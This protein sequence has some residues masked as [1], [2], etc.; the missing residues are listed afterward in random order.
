MCRTRLRAA[1]CAIP[2]LW[3]TI[4]T[5]TTLPTDDGTLSPGVLRQIAALEQEKANR[6]EVEQRIDPHLL[7]AHKMELG[8]PIADNVQT[9]RVLLDWDKNGLV[10]LDIKAEVTGALL[11]FLKSHGAKVINAFREYRSVRARM[12]LN[13]VAALAAR[14]DVSFVAPAV[15]AQ[16]N[17]VDIEGDTVHQA[18]KARQVYGVDGT[19]VR[20]GVL[21]DSVDYLTNSVVNGFVTILPGQDG[22]PATGEGTAML[23]I[24]HILAPGAQLFFA[25]AGGG[26]ANF[27]NN[28]VQLRAAGCDIIV[29]DSA[30]FDESPF[31]DGPIAEA[32][33]TVIAS[34]ALYFSS[35]GNSGSLDRGTSGAWEGDFVSGGQAPITVYNKVGQFHS[36]GGGTNYNTVLPGGSDLRVDLFWSDPLGFSVTDYDLF[37]LDQSGNVVASSTIKQAGKQDPY[38]HLDS[39]L[40][41]E[42][43]VILKVSSSGSSGGFLHLDVGRGRLSI[44]TAGRTRGHCCSSGAFAVAAVNA[45]NAY[46]FPFA[47]QDLVE[48]FSSDGPRRI[49]FQAG[50][51][52]ITPGNFSSTGGTVRQKPDI[53][54]ADGVST[55]F[56]LG[57]LNPFFGTSAAAPHAA[58]IAALVKSFNP[59]LTPPTIRNILTSS[60]LDIMSPGIDRDSGAGIVMALAALQATPLIPP[61]ITIQPQSQTVAIGSNAV[62]QVTASGSS[63][64]YRWTFNGNDLPG[65]TGPTL[66]IANAQ[67]ANSGNYRV[68]VSNSGGTATSAVAT[69]TVIVPPSISVQPQSQTVFAG[70]GVTLN[71]VANGAPTPG[72]QWYFN[73]NP[74]QNATASSFGIS[75]VQ[76]MNAGHYTVL[77]KNIG[78]SVLSQPAVLTVI[79]PAPAITSQPVSQSVLIGTTVMFSVSTSGAPPT[80]YQWRKD[81]VNIPGATNSIYAIPN[82]LTNAA[83]T[84]TVVVSNPHGT[85]TSAGA[86]LVV[87]VPPTITA[88]PVSPTVNAGSNATL[89]VVAMGTAPLSYQWYQA[90]VAIPNA[91]GSTYTIISAQPTDSGQYSVMVSNLV[92][93]VTSAAATLTVQYAPIITGQPQ[94]QP[95]HVGTTVALT[96]GGTGVPP[97]T[98][99]WF[100]DGSAISGATSSAFTILSARTNDAGNY[101]VLL[102]N[103]VGTAVSAVA[104]LGLPPTILVQPLDQTTVASD[105]ASFTVVAIG[106]GL[107]Y[108]W[109]F[110]GPVRALTN[111]TNAT[112]TLTN[113][114]RSDEGR[115][116]LVITNSFGSRDARRAS[117]TVLVPQQLSLPQRLADGTFQFLSGY[118][119]G[120]SV[121]GIP[122]RLFT[123]QFTSNFLDWLPLTNFIQ[124]SNG[125]LL[126]TDPGASNDTAR[127]YRIIQTQ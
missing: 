49:F 28:I 32:V 37:V 104:T 79:S 5:A 103:I 20:I 112:L 120:V 119:D 18:N 22:M 65:A 4:A 75:A 50:G 66:T 71:V 108:Q 67:P 2:S 113:V 80:Q 84:Y 64:S 11:D 53:A 68:L 13:E 118:S 70:D 35:A 6:T 36:F 86:V 56:P 69:L 117:L 3:L 27:S 58:A 59:T 25:T 95:L 76:N 111:A 98:Y 34:G 57:E 1:S 92:G 19:G 109:F 96:V 81:G 46:P 38:E 41:N 8:V 125:Q 21:S 110:Y 93:Q 45:Q 115:Y 40:P 122:R 87:N 17:Y 63:L 101:T 30:Y 31:Q 24:I 26:A 10:L 43:I 72:Y 74:I 48:S 123:A 14:A 78:G 7:F 39:L 97:P 105:S 73:G 100:R 106:E 85:V 15:L 9:Q 60:A 47:P 16:R 54:A 82:V 83:G 102:S 77:V 23:E 90:S 127:F 44:G 51:L 29:D 114:R 55:D 88:Q 52:P 99:Q 33:N 116:G 107:Q 12:P 91:T 121:L 94:T 126:L 42:R 124:Y 62:F 89:S 61:T